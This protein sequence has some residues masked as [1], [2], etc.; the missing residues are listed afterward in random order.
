MIIEMLK[1]STLVLSL[2]TVML[3]LYVTICVIK[4]LSRE[5]KD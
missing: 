3:A 4:G 5:T 2:E 1:Y